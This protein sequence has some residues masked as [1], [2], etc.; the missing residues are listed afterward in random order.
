MTMLKGTMLTLLGALAVSDCGGATTPDVF[1]DGGA[2][3]ATTATA[4]TATATTATATTA[5]ATTAT[6]TATAT[7]ATATATA[8]TATA[9]AATA[10]TATTSAGEASSNSAANGSST[11][12]MSAAASSPAASCAWPASLNNA[13]TTCD[14][15]RALI[16]CT[17]PSGAGCGCTTDGALECSGCGPST[18]A[19][20]Q[21]QCA[22]SEYVASCGGVGPG[23]VPQ[24][25]ANCR[26]ASAVPAGIAYYCCP[27][28]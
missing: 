27:C 6:A 21:D 25:P 11:S 5:T 23:A 28:Q 16:A 13:R 20:C 12:S 26:F 1:G 18:G 10:T 4:T 3:A 9:T 24:P 8:T 17:Y 14:A 2:A 19:T 15:A 22:A 7:T